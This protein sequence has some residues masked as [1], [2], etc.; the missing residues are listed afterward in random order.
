MIRRPPRSIRTD[1]HFP[2]T[3]LFLSHDRPP[4]EHTLMTGP[5]EKARAELVRDHRGFEDA[6]IEQI[7]RQRE[8]AGLFHQRIAER[9]DHLAIARFAALDILGDRAAGAIGR[10][11]G[12][13][14]GCQDVEISGVAGQLKK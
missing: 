11:S 2:Y 3:T 7:A 10:A 14:S 6:E 5:R 9:A 12:G 4:L 1:T 8:I 13:E